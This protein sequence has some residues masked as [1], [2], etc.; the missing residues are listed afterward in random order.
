M[1][2]VQGKC[3]QCSTQSKHETTYFGS[4]QNSEP[5]RGILL[6]VMST[7]YCEYTTRYYKILKRQ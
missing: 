4:F 6:V 7:R 2:S 3:I 5:T 1:D